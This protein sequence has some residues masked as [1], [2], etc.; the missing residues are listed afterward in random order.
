MSR[1][2]NRRGV[3]M[4]IASRN[5]DSQSRERLGSG[6]S[7]L[8]TMTGITKAITEFTTKSYNNS[9]MQTMVSFDKNTKLTDYLKNDTT[10]G[11]DQQIGV[12]Q[13]SS[14]SGA[15]ITRKL[16]GGVSLTQFAPTRE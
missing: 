4:N 2:K 1:Q 12:G 7:Q 11:R 13:A 9:A 15:D 10:L 8:T 5:H 14:F 16:Q 6:K 3:Q